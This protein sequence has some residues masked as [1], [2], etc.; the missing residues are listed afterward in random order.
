MTKWM[1]GLAMGT[2]LA[3]AG[4]DPGDETDAGVPMDSGPGVDAG[5]D[6][7]APRYYFVLIEDGSGTDDTGEHPGADI[8]AIGIARTE[9]VQFA[10]TLESTSA[11]AVNTE[12]A[13]G[14]PTDPVECFVGEFSSLGGTDGYLVV[15]FGGLEIASGDEIHV[16]EVGASACGPSGSDGG[17]IEV[18][19]GVATDPAAPSW[20]RVGTCTSFPCVQLVP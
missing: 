19:V 14:A 1:I 16:Y 12:G 7:S 4:C 2:A 11:G 5:P 15:G 10:T 20:I 3:T 8:D 13:L 6:A 18:S 17:E 9:T